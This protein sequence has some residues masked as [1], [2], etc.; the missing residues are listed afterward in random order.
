MSFLIRAFKE[1][2]YLKVFPFYIKRNYGFVP[3]AD[4][5]KSNFTDWGINE[6]LFKTH[7]CVFLFHWQLCIYIINLHIN[8]VSVHFHLPC[9]RAGN[10]QITYFTK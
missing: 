2:S 5:F 7:I 9:K 4:L 6:K 3:I 1:I 8:C 10:K